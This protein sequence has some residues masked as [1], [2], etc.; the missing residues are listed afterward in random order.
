VTQLFNAKPLAT[1]PKK[2]TL[3]PLFFEQLSTEVN[4]PVKLQWAPNIQV[5]IYQSKVR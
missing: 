2:G 1:R 5:A 4:L 3:Y